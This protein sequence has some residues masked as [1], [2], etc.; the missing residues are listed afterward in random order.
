M[1]WYGRSTKLGFN[2]R[3]EMNE[4]RVYWLIVGVVVVFVVLCLI[5]LSMASD[6]IECVSVFTEA[7]P[8]PY[9]QFNQDT[10]QMIFTTA[11][12]KEIVLNDLLER[13]LEFVG[14]AQYIDSALCS[15]WSIT[16]D[17][18]TEIEK[19]RD[20]LEAAK[21]RLQV[22]EGKEAYYK[23]KA[24]VIGDIKRAIKAL[25]GETK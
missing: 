7:E 18:R 5:K 20:D 9:I 12:G 21:A 3:K 2:R 1:I 25:K 24:R 16:P 19:A 4:R 8:Q 22:A 17:M 14:D 15:Y 10:R 13:C 23:E 11:D 6:I